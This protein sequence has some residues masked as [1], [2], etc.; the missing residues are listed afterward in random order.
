VDSP[1]H[2]IVFRAVILVLPVRVNWRSSL[3]NTS[4]LSFFQPHPLHRLLPT[5]RHTLNAEMRSGGENIM[6][7]KER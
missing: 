1:S 7:T 4:P 6:V 2:L 3:L 5:H